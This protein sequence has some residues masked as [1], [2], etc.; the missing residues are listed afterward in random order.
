MVDGKAINLGL[1]DTAGAEDY[2]RL[3]PLSYPMTNVF[4][5][6]FSIISPSSFENVGAKWVPEISHHCPG[7]PWILVG[8]KKDLRDDPAIL[9]KLLTQGHSP[10]TFEQGLAKANQLGAVTYLEN[11]ALTQ[12]G[13]KTVFDEAIRAAL[14]GGTSSYGGA[15]GSGGSGGFSNSLRS[16]LSGLGKGVKEDIESIVTALVPPSDES[17][18]V[19]VKGKTF[20]TRVGLKVGEVN[21][22][23]STLRF[24]YER[25]PDSTAQGDVEISLSF[26]VKDDV[27]P[28]SL[29]ELSG[30]VKQILSLAKNPDFKYDI[31]SAL[32][33]E[34]DGTQ[35]YRLTM[36]WHEGA[37]YEGAHKVADFYNPSQFE[38]KLELNQS[39]SVPSD[40]FIAFNFS[41]NSEVAR[42]TLRFFEAALS[43]ANDSDKRLYSL[44]RASRNFVF[45]TE[46]DNV[47]EL[48]KKAF[49]LP[50]ELQILGWSTVPLLLRQAPLGK[51]LGDPS[52]PEPARTTY[53]KLD[54]L[55]GFHGARFKAGHHALKI[56]ARHFEVFSLLP[57]LKELTAAGDD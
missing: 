54:Y 37:A 48:C 18:G 15:G 11:S 22:P 2:D 20:K 17:I 26:S 24:F 46:F 14:S 52:T 41:I 28:F 29:G 49:D 30:S 36:I 32:S 31:K 43:P 27:D 34:G 38:I 10:I 21:D 16:S 55:K 47:Q 35:I 5:V 56:E 7:V 33:R 8:N 4:L 57:P 19:D 39:P 40:Q 45:E 9:D 44:F 51:F 13:L 12:E 1:W 3:R 42:D 53:E 6:E 50:E 25:E 23:Q